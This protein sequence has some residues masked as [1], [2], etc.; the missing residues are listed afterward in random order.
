M[1]EHVVWRGHLRLALVS[2]PVALFAARRDSGSLHFHFI[3]PATGNRVR[4]VTLDAETDAEI[5]RRD[6]VRGYE[7]RKDHYVLMAEEDFDAAQIESS[8]T[9]NVRKFVTADSIDPLYYDQ[10]YYMVP[11]GE[12]GGDVF[13][14]LH[15]AFA[16]SGRVALSRLVIGRRERAVAIMT[17]GRGLVLHTL[18]EARDI[19]DSKPLFDAIPAGA[20]DKEMVALARQLIE[21]QGGQYDPAADN[22]DRYETRLRAVIDAKLRGE[23]VDPPEEAEDDRTNVVDLMAMLK[24]SLGGPMA[25]RTGAKPAKAKGKAGK[26]KAIKA[27]GAK[28]RRTAG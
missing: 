3:N 2:C 15:E 21:R 19:N 20:A 5:A 24:K 28:P 25:E 4:T 6:L 13:V 14:V 23:G 26:T 18:H 16:E 9:L 22:E 1:A 11:D 17:L 8:S 12:A 10:S 7:F 27:S